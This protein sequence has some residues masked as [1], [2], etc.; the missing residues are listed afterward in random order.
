MRCMPLFVLSFG[1]ALGSAKGL[2]AQDGQPD[3]L[4]SEAPTLE[5]CEAR[6][7]GLQLR[8]EVDRRKVNALISARDTLQGQLDNCAVGTV[9]EA[10]FDRTNALLDELEARL[11]EIEASLE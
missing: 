4:S 3:G 8:A 11:T 10:D 2:S 6:V 5:A 1:I 9:P 7:A